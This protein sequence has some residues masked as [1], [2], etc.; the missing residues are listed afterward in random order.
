MLK[1]KQT[2]DKNGKPVKKLPRPGFRPRFNHYYEGMTRQQI[3]QDTAKTAVRWLA[4]TVFFYVYWTAML[5]L[6]S[7][8]LLN[9]WHVTLPQILLIA[10]ALCIVSSIVYA[11]ALV[12]R[13]FYY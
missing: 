5:L 13:K 8:F 11:L 4:G 9:V 2:V 6:A 12:H 1:R 3:A 7:L 10:L